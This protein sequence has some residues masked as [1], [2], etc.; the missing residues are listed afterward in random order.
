MK[1]TLFD[2]SI[3]R[4]SFGDFDNN[5]IASQVINSG[6]RLSD[7][8]NSC[9]FEDTVF[10]PEQGS[11]GYNLIVALRDYFQ[12]GG[13]DVMEYWSQIH[14][15]LESTNTHHHGD[16]EMA[17]VYYVKVPE[18]SGDIVF[19][20]EHL[21]KSLQPEERD[22]IVFPGWLKH[23]VSKNMSND[24]RVSIAGNLKRI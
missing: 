16:Y 18:G 21:N 1:E 24:I 12:D 13:F 20:V 3:F 22:L 5:T 9:L 7:D 14:R 4:T 11:P 6:K 15:P 17:F 2:I 8:P 19:E 10:N 23:R